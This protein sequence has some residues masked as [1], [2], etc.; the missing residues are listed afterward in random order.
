MF[1]SKVSWPCLTSLKTGYLEITTIIKFIVLKSD[2][3]DIVANMIIE[4]RDVIFFEKVF[5]M[6]TGISHVNSDDDFTHNL[7]SIP[8]H[9]KRMIGHV[10]T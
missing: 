8:D 9:V 5:S 7:S 3:N 6:K 4:F 1:L 2:I 10:C